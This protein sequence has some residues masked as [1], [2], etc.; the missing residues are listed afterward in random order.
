[1]KGNTL[2]GEINQNYYNATPETASKAYWVI[3]TKGNCYQKTYHAVPT[4]LSQQAA[5]TNGIQIFPNPF[6]QEIIIQS[7]R[8]LNNAQVLVF[9]SNGRNLLSESFNGTSSTL[10]LEQLPAGLY[11]LQ[12]Q[13]ESGLVST[14]KLVKY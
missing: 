4:S 3:S 10:N 12:I 14:S 9:D 2:T 7:E 5:L 6:T 11:M 1:L 8:N 13:D